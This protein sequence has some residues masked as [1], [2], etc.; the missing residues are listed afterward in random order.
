MMTW[1]MHALRSTAAAAHDLRRFTAAVTPQP[2]CLR[3]EHRAGLH[4]AALHHLGWAPGINELHRLHRRRLALGEQHHVPFKANN[5]DNLLGWYTVEGRRTNAVPVVSGNYLLDGAGWAMNG[6]LLTNDSTLDHRFAIYST[7][8]NAV[9][10]LDRVT[11]RADVTLTCEQGGLTAI[12][13]D[14]FTRETRTLYHETA[15]GSG[16][17]SERL[18]GTSL[19]R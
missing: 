19:T 6:E 16:T 18:D 12:S 17:T 4:A 2:R 5:T 1:L 14:A 8:G 10:Y 9:V 7:P 11:A 3:P 13:T 15:D